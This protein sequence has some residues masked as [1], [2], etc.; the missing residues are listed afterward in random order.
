MRLRRLRALHKRRRELLGRGV[1]RVSTNSPTESV[2]VFIRSSMP[3]SWAVASIAEIA[4][5]NPPLARP[6]KDDDQPVGFVPMAA[7]A[8]QFGGIKTAEHRLYAKVK[9]GYT[10]FVPGDVIMAKITPCME[11]GK[12]GVVRGDPQTVFF[13]STEFHVLRPR[14]GIA[15]DW[16]GLFLSQESVR[17]V[18]RLRMKGSAGQLRVPSGFFEQ[19]AIPVA[20]SEEQRRISDRVAELLSDLDAGIAALERVKRNLVRYRAAVLHAAVTGQL[21]A[22]WRERNGPPSET[23][24]QLLERILIERRRIWEERTLAKHQADGKQPPKGWK[25]RYNGP[26]SLPKSHRTSVLPA[27]PAN[28][29][30]AALDQLLV[31]VQNGTSV[32]PREPSGVPILRISAVRPMRVDL[33]DTR[34]LTEQEA[35]DANSWIAE[36]DLLFTRYNGSAHLCG[37]CGRVRGL[38][39]KV[40]Y[41]DK[42]IRCRTVVSDVLPDFLELALSA[43]FSRRSIELCLRTTAGQ[44]GVSGADLKQTPVPVPPCAE[45]Q[46]IVELANE[47][48]SQIESLSSEVERNM[49]RA[50]R[51]RQSILKSAFEGHLVPQD[52]ADEPASVLIERI[53]AASLPPAAKKPRKTNTRKTAKT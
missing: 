45:Q 3:S 7:V 38:V 24:Q 48:L 5:L 43:G 51:L 47:R 14:T 46:A 27:V 15:P 36:N 42:L 10:P 31:S 44:V 18:A 9:K 25:A 40:A 49:A 16:I 4:A 28:W 29:C 30:W 37:V 11:N 50:S 41:P 52:P 17:R 32:V 23:G 34:Y 21:T 53:R 19:L 12:G 2:E 26:F 1:C 13:G 8:E 22:A 6:I 20:P 35:V 33:A 39:G